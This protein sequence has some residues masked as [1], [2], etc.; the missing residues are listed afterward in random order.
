MNKS[1]F[2]I[3]AFISKLLIAVILCWVIYRQVFANKNLTEVLSVLSNDKPNTNLL[4]LLIALCLVLCNWGL[5]A[6]RWRM[7]VIQHH[8]ISYKD[9]VKAILMGVTLGI[10]S[11]QRVGEYAGRLLIVP[12]DKNWLSVKSSFYTSISLN[13]V[14]ISFGLLALYFSISKDIISLNVSPQIIVAG[15]IISLV[16]LLVLFMYL[17]VFE[18]IL[19]LEFLFKYFKKWG[20]FVG[21][22]F[23][24]PILIKLLFYS[25]LRYL[26]F[27][28]QYYLLLKYFGIQLNSLEIFASIAV[29]YLLQSSLPLPAL[30]SLLARGEIAL[31]V[32]SNFDVN[33]II[34][35]ASTFSLWIINLMIPAL[36]GLVI[37]WKTKLFETLGFGKT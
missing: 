16:I 15:A 1:S 28:T 35:F 29:I 24:K 32:F 17:Q 14:I 4:Y 30:L 23:D 20:K 27:L 3:F 11:P 5:E 37:I 22:E 19:H 34:I 8:R 36:L 25:I 33:E 6:Y 21:Y 18:R 2:R 7:I 10:I 12:S 31:L 26:V 13:I 9:S